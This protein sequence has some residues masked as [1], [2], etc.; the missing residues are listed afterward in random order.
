MKLKERAINAVNIILN[1]DPTDSYLE[2]A[3]NITSKM[4]AGMTYT[5]E[6][7]TYFRSDRITGG[8]AD[9][10]L[11]NAFYNRIAVDVSSVKLIHARL[12]ENGKYVETIKSPL[13]NCLNLEAN[14]D[15]TGRQLM[16]DTV[17]SMFDEGVVAIVPT[18]TEIDIDTST[19]FAIHEVRVCRILEW[20]PKSVKVEVYNDETG[21]KEPVIISK[22]KVAIIEN[23][24]YLIMNEPNST[25]K[26]LARK[27]ALL[28]KVDEDACSGKLDLIVQ[29]PYGTKSELK[30][31]RANSR[32]NDIEKQLTGSKYGIAYI[33]ATEKITQLN[34]P[35]ENNLL[36]QI[37]SL[38][39]QA[40]NQL[41]MTEAVF[42]G[43]ANEEEMQ[44][45]YNNSLEPILDCIAQAMARSFLSKTA[46]TQG[47]TIW[48]F[49]DQFKLI[50][51]SKLGEVI[52]V[53]SRNAIFSANEV[54]SLLGRKPDE[55][56]ESNQ[57]SN[58][59]MPSLEPEEEIVEGE[60][61][62]DPIMH[63]VEEELSIMEGLNDLD[64]ID[65]ML[66][67]LESGDE[68][69]MTHSI[70]DIADEFFHYASEY[71]DPVKAHEYYMKNRELK[72][73][74]STSGLNDKGKGAAAYVKDQLNKER[75]KKN[76]TSDK[77]KKDAVDKASDEYSTIAEKNSETAKKLKEGAE[78]TTKMIVE[79]H[80]KNM[81]NKVSRLR[82]QLKGM[83]KEQK[84]A[85]A[86]RIA[87]MIGE[88]K[89]SNA[90]QRE[91][92]NAKLKDDKAAFEGFKKTKNAKAKDKSNKAKDSARSTNKSE[93]AA[94]KD[95]MNT[96]Y[97]DYLSKLKSDSGMQK[98][99]KEKKA[100]T[101]KA[102]SG[103]KK[104]YV[105]YL[106]K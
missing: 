27:L 46:R 65:E 49:M 9:K 106:N 39:K 26:R 78:K 57:L 19:G 42:N 33:D 84:A 74:R 1:K 67:A 77:Q 96:K 73:R 97:E 8:Y 37:E 18:V 34:R 17:L 60:E 52:D 71:Y 16:L 30:A 66:L 83:S 68:D 51:L 47:Q 95:D 14:I 36:A 69:T 29:L 79:T 44:N 23:P 13:N 43:T 55:S 72:G 38:T 104:K 41:G 11:I 54:R 89:E 21:L 31:D 81:Q 85:N 4:K 70:D 58:K 15:Q 92:L 45:Y 87:G 3:W 53:L 101:K 5:E 98:Q 80:K 7:T 20:Y 28:D 82:A 25:M 35:A 63:S 48:Y 93:K 99:K 32:R 91:E 22:K 56:D 50:P 2:H 105:T 12:D 94:N 90:K 61:T 40:M 76:D 62:D 88:L 100:S 102:S 59:N 10:S 75:L 64:T 86:E 24:L 6:P 103:G